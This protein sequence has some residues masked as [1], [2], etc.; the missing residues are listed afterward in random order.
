MLSRHCFIHGSRWLPRQP[1]FSAHAARTSATQT[2]HRAQVP[3][4]VCQQ[5]RAACKGRSLGVGYREKW[6]PEDALTGA[7]ALSP[8][9]AARVDSIRGG[10]AGPLTRSSRDLNAPQELLPVRDRKCCVRG[11]SGACGCVAGL[12]FLSR[13][14]GF[15]SSSPPLDRGDGGLQGGRGRGSTG[16]GHC[17]RRTQP[18]VPGRVRGTFCTGESAVWRDL[19]GPELRARS[20]GVEFHGSRRRLLAPSP[21]LSG[22]RPNTAEAY[23]TVV[24]YSGI[25]LQVIRITSR[26]GFP[27]DGSGPVS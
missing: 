23:V 21:R 24:K 5:R 4:T 13:L 26:P 2:T 1:R 18:P 15:C 10:G 17:S 7:G 25:Y 11:I 14:L 27:L 20:A 16:R 9:P 12:G 6:S 22:T 3:R 8:A 19:Q